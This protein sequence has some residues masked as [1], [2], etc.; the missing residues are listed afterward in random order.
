MNPSSLLSSSQKNEPYVHPFLQEVVDVLVMR[1]LKGH[2]PY[3]IRVNPMLYRIIADLDKAAKEG[4]GMGCPVVADPE[5][6]RVEV[7]G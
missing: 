4:N 3:V 5:C 6:P 7:V 2:R 1:R